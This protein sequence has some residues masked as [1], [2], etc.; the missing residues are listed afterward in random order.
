MSVGENMCSTYSYLYRTSVTS[1]EM[2]SDRA[3]IRLRIR[4]VMI[5]IRGCRPDW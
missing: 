5:F 2:L 3:S 1:F 4:S